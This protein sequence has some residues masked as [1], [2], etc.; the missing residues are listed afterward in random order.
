[1]P[2]LHHYLTRNGETHISRDEQDKLIQQNYYLV[3]CRK[4]LAQRNRLYRKIW[5]SDALLSLA[6]LA[7]GRH[8]LILL[9]NRCL[10]ESFIDVDLFPSMR[11]CIRNETVRR[12]VPESVPVCSVVSSIPIIVFIPSRA[13]FVFATTDSRCCRKP[14]ASV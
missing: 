5:Q 9:Y 11:Q 4:S 1:M 3:K 12:N 10:Q 14:P 2:V 6:F 8:Q 7:L 13:D